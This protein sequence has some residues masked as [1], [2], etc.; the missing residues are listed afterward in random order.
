MHKQ[1]VPGIRF[2]FWVP[3]NEATF[4]DC[5]GRSLRSQIVWEGAY[6]LRLSGKEARGALT[7]L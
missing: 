7:D 4:S 5:L 2:N 1:C 6:V 3:G